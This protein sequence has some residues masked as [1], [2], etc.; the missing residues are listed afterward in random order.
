MVSQVCIECCLPLIFLSD[1]DQ[2]VGIAYVW[3]SEDGGFLEQFESRRDER[4]GVPIFDSNAFQTTVVNIGPQAPVLLTDK[5]KPCRCRRR[6]GT[7][8]THSQ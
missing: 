3:F 7:D 6:R 2:M 4:E 1:L 8:E 5:E